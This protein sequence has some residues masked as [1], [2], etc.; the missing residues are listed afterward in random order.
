M[1]AN[2]AKKIT[3]LY[4]G[5]LG[6][7]DMRHTKITATNAISPPSVNSDTTIEYMAVTPA[8]CLLKTAAVWPGPIPRSRVTALLNGCPIPLIRL[9]RLPW[10]ESLGAKPNLPV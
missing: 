6:G 8:P 5:D 3:C 7:K 4:P 9:Y 10:V 2:Q 1:P